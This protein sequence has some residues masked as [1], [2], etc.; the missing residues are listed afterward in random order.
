MANVTPRAIIYKGQIVRFSNKEL[1]LITMKAAMS[2]TTPYEAARE[3]A[4]SPARKYAAGQGLVDKPA[5]PKS[6]SPNIA[7]LAI[8]NAYIGNIYDTSN[9]EDTFDALVDK[10][11]Q[12]N[13]VLLAI[14][15]YVGNT[16]DSHTSERAFDALVDD[17][18]SLSNAETCKATL[19][20]FLAD[21]SPI[22]YN[23]MNGAL[24]LYQVYEH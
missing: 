9:S 10:P 16:D 12:P 2:G 20:A 22:N 14:S 13:T 11:T 3:V 24:I 19:E 23:A 8:Y 5:Q 15:E 4:A 7:L 1:Q 17:N 21:P 6:A 18:Q